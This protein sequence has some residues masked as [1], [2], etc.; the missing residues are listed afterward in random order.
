MLHS[1]GLTLVLAHIYLSLSSP[2]QTTPTKTSH[3]SWKFVFIASEH[4][5][6][7]FFT[8]CANNS[9]RVQVHEKTVEAQFLVAQRNKGLNE[10]KTQNARWEYETGKSAHVGIDVKLWSEIYAN[11]AI[12]GT[13]LESTWGWVNV[14]YRENRNSSLLG[15]IYFCDAV[16]VIIWLRMKRFHRNPNRVILRITFFRQQL[17]YEMSTITFPHKCHFIHVSHTKHASYRITFRPAITDFAL[18]R[19]RARNE[20]PSTYRCKLMVEFDNPTLRWC[21]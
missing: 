5:G 6:T 18:S 1:S 20:R 2:Y 19:L 21:V 9:S 15:E 3:K 16:G 11:S 4:C 17:N 8:F 13:F 10:I 7:V 12:V 14:T